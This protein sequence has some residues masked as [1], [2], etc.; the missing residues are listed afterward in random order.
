MTDSELAQDIIREKYPTR[1][2][3]LCDFIRSVEDETARD[4][5]DEAAAGTLGVRAMMRVLD[6]HAP[7]IGIRTLRRHRAEGH[8]NS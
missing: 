8:G 2:C 1:G 7:G 6:K 4:L 3:A 5:L